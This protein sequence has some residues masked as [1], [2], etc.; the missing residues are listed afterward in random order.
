MTPAARLQAAIEVLD[1]WHEGEVAER[2]LT[3]WARGARYA[4]SKDRRAVRDHVFDVLR[5]KISCARAGGGESGRAWIIGLLRLNGVDPAAVFTGEGYGPAPMT[6][7]ERAYDPPQV[8]PEADMPDWLVEQFQADHGL[9]APRLIAALTHRAPVYLRANLRRATAAAVV[10]RLAE[11]GVEAAPVP[12]SETA[13]EVLSGAPRLKQTRAFQMGLFEFQD[14]SVQRACAAITWPQRGRILD[15]CAG[16]GGKALAIAAVSDADIDVHDAAPRR[17]AELPARAER[18]GVVLTQQPTD[19]L[20]GP[21]DLVLCDVPC[22]GSGTWRRDPEAKWRLT[23]AR[24]RELCALQG[25]I[26]SQA[27]TLLRPGGRLVYMTCSLLSVENEAQIQAFLAEDPGFALTASHVDTPL[28]ASDGF[29]VAELT[30]RRQR[31]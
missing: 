15:Y 19:A 18:A 24:L 26:L 9:D 11:E 28:T 12:G 1:R 22:S 6:E 16:G 25:H 3:A 14:L 30:D 27:A 8:L 2:A 29:F 5:R 4:G 10:Q 31:A 13:V 17:M 20:T 7:A 21:Y 23:E